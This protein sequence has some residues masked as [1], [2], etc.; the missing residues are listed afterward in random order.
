V[1]LTSKLT[2]LETKEDIMDWLTI[3]KNLVAQVT[4]EQFVAMAK[5]VYKLLKG[6]K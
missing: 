4:E 1:C 2:R 3:V 5:L 6:L